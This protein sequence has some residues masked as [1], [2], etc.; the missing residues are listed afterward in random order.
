[1]LGLAPGTARPAVVLAIR[2]AGIL[3]G[4]LASGVPLP[5]LPAAPLA[6]FSLDPLLVVSFAVDSGAAIHRVKGACHVIVAP[7]VARV[8][9]EHSLPDWSQPPEAEFVQGVR[10]PRQR[11]GA[12]TARGVRAVVAGPPLELEQIP[13]QGAHRAPTP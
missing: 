13:V 3:P 11:V 4:S 2:P 12:V 9:A 6:G 1:M 10:G 7:L 5:Q 8:A